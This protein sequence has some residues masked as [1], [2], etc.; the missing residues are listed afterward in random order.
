M[1]K[2]TK[3]HLVKYK[4][5]P[6]LEEFEIKLKTKLIKSGLGDSLVDEKTGELVAYSA[7][8][9]IETHDEEQFIKVFRKHNYMIFELSKRAIKVMEYIFS[10]AQKSPNQDVIY[11]STE[12]ALEYF[13]KVSKSCGKSTYMLALKE[14]VERGVLAKKNEV[15]RYFI[16][17]E[18]FFNGDRAFFLTELRKTRREK[19]K[20][21]SNKGANTLDIFELSQGKN[22]EE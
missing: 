15:N 22:N 19:L 16:N 18:V 14:I 20:T 5:N 4:E 17:P 9:K 11:L 6:F 10:E 12:G 3:S 21:I 1:E 8:H 2:K 13:K 7:I